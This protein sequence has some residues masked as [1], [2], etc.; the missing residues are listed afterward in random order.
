MPFR[1]Y[2]R[3]KATL[4]RSLLVSGALV[5]LMLAATAQFM[6]AQ[7]GQ[8]A[9]GASAATSRAS[10]TASSPAQSPQQSVLTLKRQV[11]L[12]L[13]PVVVRDK[14]G[15][16]VGTLTRDDFHIFSDGKPQP[17]SSFSVET[18]PP[19]GKRAHADSAFGDALI[20]NIAGVRP[21]H[22]F[23]Y[24]VDDVH[25]PA[26][27]LIRV[28]EAARKH[29][30]SDMEPDDRAAVFS[31]SG[32]VE[33]T[34]TGDRAQLDRAFDRI[35]PEFSDGQNKCPYMN[36][37]LAQ[38]IMREYGSDLT[39]VWD[40]ATDDAWNC[41]FHKE[42]D[43]QPRARQMALDAARQAVEAG[44]A[45]SLKSLLA[46]QLAVRRLAAMPGSRTLVLISPGFQTGDDYPQQDAAI[47]LATK[48]NIVVNALDASGLY[49][50]VRQADAGGPTTPEADQAEA[51]FNR[52]ARILQ[53]AVMAYLADG[54]GGKLFRDSND[55]VRGLG[56]VAAPPE[57]VYMLGFSPEELKKSARYHRLKVEVPRHHGWTVQARLGY[58]ADTISNAPAQAL[59]VELEQAL[60]SRDVVNSMPVTLKEGYS[61][62]GGDSRELDVITHIDLSGID[63]KKVNQSN[64]D[65]LILVC[66]LFDVNGNFL[67]GKRKELGLRLANDVIN[68][69]TQGMNI[70]TSFDVKPGAYLI[71]VVV[72]D[73]GN[74]LL[75][76]VNGSGF[77]P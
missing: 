31:T 76:A 46:I 44:K 68:R 58:Y 4:K 69:I 23:A 71:R 66:G 7:Q 61:N 41:L 10:V 51:P 52:Q 30:A 19:A 77:V 67:Q 57:Y 43:L 32:N 74:G 8:P 20:R 37:Y 17:V 56:Q 73:S 39:P 25:M 65:N 12:V 33:M 2:R 16:A 18:N 27:E 47:D 75:S 38:Q 60:F 14:K 5:A 54:T 63:L 48:Q 1:A 3:S 24:L 59:S 70:K 11:N 62:Q 55:L 34:F 40:A 22:F 29:F 72:R 50:G 64:V 28:K 35:M 49:T 15:N 53:T 26:A 13:V 6:L 36:F 21:A 42:A 9:E 45:D